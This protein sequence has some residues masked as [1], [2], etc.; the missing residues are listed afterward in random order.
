MI[1]FQVFMFLHYLPQFVAQCFKNKI[2][3]FF[4]SQGTPAIPPKTSRPF[5]AFPQHQ[6]QPPISTNA[7]T[8]LLHNQSQ[9]RQYFPQ[10]QQQQLPN[11]FQS[12]HTS[13]TFNSDQQMKQQQQHRLSGNNNSFIISNGGTTNN[14]TVFHPSSM[15]ESMNQGLET[16]LASSSSSSSIGLTTNGG[17]TATRTHL[18][19]ED[20]KLLQEWSLLT[21]ATRNG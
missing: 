16:S 15:T 19:S 20:E 9:Q 14:N 12:S 8:Q 6:Q 18:N 2:S 4:S 1:W 5:A 7:Q 10:H 3:L 17:K 13:S 21:V 11:A